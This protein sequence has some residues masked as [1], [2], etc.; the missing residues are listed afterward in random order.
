VGVRGRPW[1]G[2]PA[3]WRYRRREGSRS[4]VGAADR[5]SDA[6]DALY[7]EHGGGTGTQGRGTRVIQARRASLRQGPAVPRLVVGAMGE[8]AAGAPG[9]VVVGAAGAGRADTSLVGTLSSGGAHAAAHDGR[10][11]THAILRVVCD[12]GPFEGVQYM[13]EDS[14]RI[15]FTDSP[16]AK[17]YVDDSE[18]GL[19][20]AISTSWIRRRRRRRA[21]P[22]TLRR[23]ARRGRGSRLGRPVPSRSH[24]AWD[25]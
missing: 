3:R 1:C 8:S 9:F 15:L 21:T 10:M 2:L 22:R 5:V 13:D 7:R 14:G 16:L 4:R 6:V 11:Q 23:R 12:D 24:C 20:V 25:C 17:H 18:R 19:L